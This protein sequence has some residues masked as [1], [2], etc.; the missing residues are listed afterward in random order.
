MFFMPYHVL[1]FLIRTIAGGMDVPQSTVWNVL[2][3]Q[4]LHPYHLQ[5]VHAMGPA[6]FALRANF[7]MWFLHR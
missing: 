2:F 6:D 7:R 4:K 1:P 5:T 3:E